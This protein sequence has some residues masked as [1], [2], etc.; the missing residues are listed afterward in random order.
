LQ[1]NK[2]NYQLQVLSKLSNLD[3]FIQHFIQNTMALNLKIE[4]T[5]TFKKGKIEGE[6]KEK[7]KM[8]LSLYKMK[9]LSIMEIA[10][11]AGVTVEYVEIVIKA[12]KAMDK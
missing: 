6:K 2:A 5:F 10:L 3:V 4:D 1:G 12:E 11:A 7:D 9:K 8:I